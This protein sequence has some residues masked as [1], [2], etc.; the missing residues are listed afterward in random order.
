VLNQRRDL[1]DIAR[2][3]RPSEGKAIVSSDKE[4]EIPVKGELPDLIESK[5]TFSRPMITK[6]NAGLVN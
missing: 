4:T 2:S 6:R 3:C 1:G 5:M